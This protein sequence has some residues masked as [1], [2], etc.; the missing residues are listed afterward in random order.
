MIHFITGRPGAGKSY[1]A[2]TLLVKECINTTRF[3]VTN[4]AVDG[5]KLAQYLHDNHDGNT[6]DILNRL[7]ILDDEEIQFFYCHRNP[8]KPALEITYNPKNKKPQSYDAAGAAGDGGCLY[9]LDEVHLAFAARDWMMMGNACVFYCSQHR[10]LSDDILLVTQH[11]KLVDSQLRAL[12]QDWITIRHHAKEMLFFWKQP[13]VFT[14]QVF[15]NMPTA[16]EKPQEKG[17]FKLDMKIAELY[18]TAVGVG[19]HAENSDAD[20]TMDNRRGLPFWTI[21]VA[22]LIALFFLVKLPSACSSLVAG[23]ITEGSEE[24]IASL[25][26]NSTVV[27]VTNNVPAIKA[28]PSFPTNMPGIVVKKE[29]KSMVAG[30]ITKTINGEWEFVALLTSGEKLSLLDG[31]ISDIFSTHVTD[32]SGAI[33]RFESPI[34]LLKLRG[35]DIIK[36]E[37]QK[38]QPSRKSRLK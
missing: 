23:K 17:W 12:A 10:K 5:E 16:N 1:Y 8:L 33:Y 35:L 15:L 11:C 28:F 4:L 20:K 25:D 7:H 18:D 2:M 29:E 36:Q 24:V 37:F 6:F 9:I 27:A 30:F 38:T 26:L 31:E 22:I 19:I 34:N 3:I 32:A 13:N 14:K 21:P